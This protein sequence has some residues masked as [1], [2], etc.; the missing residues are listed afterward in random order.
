MS[1]KKKEAVP[2]AQAI[3]PDVLKNAVLA[4]LHDEEGQMVLPVLFECLIP[5]YDGN[6]LTRPGGKLSVSV[7]GAYW[8]LQLD[9]PYE[10]LT[11]RMFSASLSSALSDLNAYLGSG[12][13]V[14]APMF[15]RNKKPLP[16]LDKPVE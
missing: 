9:M 1:K 14:F 10:R 16:R 5:Q 11:V 12:K 15:E 6:A 4:R 3:V 2:A 8:R 7:E 13:A